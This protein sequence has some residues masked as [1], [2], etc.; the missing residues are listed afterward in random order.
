[1]AAEAAL[2]AHA[3]GE[4]WL[5][6]DRLLANQKQLERPALAHYASDLQL[7]AAQFNAALDQKRYAAAVAADKALG[8]Q[9]SVVGMPTMFLNGQR[10]LNAVDQEGVVDAI[11]ERLAAAN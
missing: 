2:A 10:L 5:F 1:L 6:Y 11:E 7:D 4:F 3:Q 9:L 8:D